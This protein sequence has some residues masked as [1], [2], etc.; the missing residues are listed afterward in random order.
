VLVKSVL[1]EQ[2]V[3]RATLDDGAIFDDQDLRGLTDRAEAW[4]I[5]KLVRAVHQAKQRF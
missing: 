2:L 5:T 3:V 1:A 4:A